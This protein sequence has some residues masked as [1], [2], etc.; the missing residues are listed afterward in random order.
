M[1]LKSCFL[2][3]HYELALFCINGYF[4]K[5]GCLLT[6]KHLSN[7]TVSLLAVMHTASFINLCNNEAKLG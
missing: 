4:W 3:H 1:E 5:I 6:W 7:T 2:P